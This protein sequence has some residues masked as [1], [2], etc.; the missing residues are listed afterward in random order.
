MIGAPMGI[1]DSPKLAHSSSGSAL[2]HAASNA[3]QDAVGSK[4]AAAAEGSATTPPALEDPLA[5][6]SEEEINALFVK[7]VEEE[8]NIK[9]AT[10]RSGMMKL[11]VDQKKKMLAAKM[12]T[13]I[14]ERQKPGGKDDPAYFVRELRASFGSSSAARFELLEA[15]RVNLR[16]QPVSWVREF[17]V[18]RGLESLA[19]VFQFSTQQCA[20]ASQPGLLQAQSQQTATAVNLTSER[21]NVLQCAKCIRAFANNRFGACA[22]LDNR[23]AMIALAQSLDPA[24]PVLM[25]EAAD[26]L[27]A[28]C[29]LE[30][31]KGYAQRTRT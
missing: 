1:T 26:L 2:A 5:G 24:E 17:A 31:G 8:L 23:V 4:R 15:V 19:A 28:L 3:K 30:H 14:A 22:L 6:K 10:K 29:F 20:I 12:L 16:T 21:R 27:A 7:F 11:A 25:L 13:E 18:Q 9:D